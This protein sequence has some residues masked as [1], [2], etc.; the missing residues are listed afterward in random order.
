MP[1]SRDPEDRMHA[2][3]YIG[4][5]ILVAIFALAIVGGAVWL[6]NNVTGA[7]SQ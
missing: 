3:G 7:A 2:A 5:I 4:G 1:D 6:W